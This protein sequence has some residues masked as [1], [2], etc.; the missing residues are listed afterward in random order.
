MTERSVH[1]ALQAIL[2]A[3]EDTLPPH[4]YA[5]LVR[6]LAPH[7]PAR[8]RRMTLYRHLETARLPQFLTGLQQKTHA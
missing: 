3:L 2:A 4:T 1:D 6:N 7:N 5:L 8:W